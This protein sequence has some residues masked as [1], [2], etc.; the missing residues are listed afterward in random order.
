MWWLCYLAGEA[1]ARFGD[2][3]QLSPPRA[4]SWRLHLTPKV[5]LLM[6]VMSRGKRLHLR[7]NDRWRWATSRTVRRDPRLEAIM[8]LKPNR[9]MMINDDVQESLTEEAQGSLTE[10]QIRECLRKGAKSADELHR[11]LEHS[12]LAGIS[13]SMGLRLR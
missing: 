12:H 13:R 11:I 2:T 1:M 4:K 6:A 10:E 8:S 5:C 3:Y 9:G 7:S